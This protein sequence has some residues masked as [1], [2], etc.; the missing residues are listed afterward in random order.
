MS[1]QKRAI[2]KNFLNLGDT[3]DGTTINEAL[4]GRIILPEGGGAKTLL[5]K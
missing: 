4:K 3:E 1:E 5:R 2:S